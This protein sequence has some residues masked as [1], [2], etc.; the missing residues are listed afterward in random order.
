[1]P[2]PCR[3]GRLEPSSLQLSLSIPSCL[4]HPLAAEMKLLC[5]L[6]WIGWMVGIKW[7]WVMRYSRRSIGYCWSIIHNNR[8]AKS[9]VPVTNCRF[10]WKTG[11]DNPFVTLVLPKRRGLINI[12]RFS[13]ASISLT[14][15]YS[16]TLSVKYSPSTIVPN[17]NGLFILRL[18]S[19]RLFSQI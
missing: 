19:M 2:T 15:P 4:F 16:A 12:R 10:N 5:H 7:K 17:L 14:L 1:M 11:R 3:K 9:A 13:L 18:F 6:S 8:A